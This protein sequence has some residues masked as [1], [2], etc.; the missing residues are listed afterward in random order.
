MDPVLTDKI[1]MLLIPLALTIV[2][3]LVI[4][5]IARIV[6]VSA[7]AVRKKHIQFLEGLG[8]LYTG[9]PNYD[10]LDDLKKMFILMGAGAWATMDHLHIGEYE[11]APMEFFQYHYSD[12]KTSQ[13]GGTKVFSIVMHLYLK[14]VSFPVFALTKKNLSPDVGFFNVKEPVEV[15]GHPAFSRRYHLQGNNADAVKKIFSD[16][17]LYFLENRK[18]CIFVEA[19]DHDLLI[20]TEPRNREGRLDLRNAIA[21]MKDFRDIGKMFE[22]AAK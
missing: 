15:D 2:I 20:F 11:G 8:I 7:E 10:L 12:R 14:S 3:V 22:E 1:F 4:C 21:I 13:P 19:N 17:V 9:E 16:K 6:S 5:Y 18:H